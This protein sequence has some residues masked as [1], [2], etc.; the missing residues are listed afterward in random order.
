[1]MLNADVRRG[2][3]GLVISFLITQNVVNKL[4]CGVLF[5]ISLFDPWHLFI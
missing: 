1:M 3:R 4:Y 5:T 2:E